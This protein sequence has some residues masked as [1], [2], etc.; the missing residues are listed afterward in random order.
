ME[1]RFRQVVA[2]LVLPV[3]LLAA[4]CSDDEGAADDGNGA[5][6]EA[7]NASTE[8]S[9]A[10]GEGAAGEATDPEA[11]L[12]MGSPPG[13]GTPTEELNITQIAA[14]TSAVQTLTQLVVKAGLVPA[15]RDTQDLTVFAP[16]NDAFDAI[17]RP[18]YFSVVGDN[19]TLTQI[20]TLH[21]VPGVY[22]LSDLMD[23]DGQTLT[24]LEGGELLVE[25]DGDN[26]IV[27]GATIAAPD[28]KASNGVIHAVDTVIT[29][30]NG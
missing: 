29:Q 18:T 20:L 30:A 10:D 1:L 22:E 14:G 8:G 28:I 17:P 13:E 24:T 12:P 11:V 25:I 2:A 4:G 7:D 27:G 5:A 15:L 9:A 3:A 23:L 26:V 21:V 16:V 19:A 6:A